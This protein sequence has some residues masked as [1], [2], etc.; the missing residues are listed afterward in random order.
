[1]ISEQKDPQGTKPTIPLIH[2]L[3]KILVEQ[4]KKSNN[5]TNRFEVQI[6]DNQGFSKVYKFFLYQFLLK[7]LYLYEVC[8]C[9]KAKIMLMIGYIYFNL[10][11]IINL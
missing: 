3:E 9:K 1:M 7:T 2:Y 6:G 11:P 4:N 8:Y 5:A 10:Q